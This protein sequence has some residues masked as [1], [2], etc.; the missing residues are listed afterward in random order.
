MRRVSEEEEGGGWR[1]ACTDSAGSSRTG[2]EP[3]SVLQLYNASAILK[4]GWP[5][6]FFRKHLHTLLKNFTKWLSTKRYESYGHAWL[7]G[8]P[9][10][11]LLQDFSERHSNN[12]KHQVLFVDVISW[13]RARRSQFDRLFTKLRVEPSQTT[14]HGDCVTTTYF[15]NMFKVFQNLPP[16]RNWLQWTNIF[17]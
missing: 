11:I 6:R 16:R 13:W 14:C 1:S 5:W 9:S 4:N 3:G 12:R 17:K 7:L 10:R 2:T 8:K 15:S